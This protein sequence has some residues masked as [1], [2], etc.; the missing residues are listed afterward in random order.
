MDLKRA[1]DAFVWVDVCVCASVL[2][3]VCVCG[4]TSVYVLVSVPVCECESCSIRRNNPLLYSLLIELFCEAL[5]KIGS[6]VLGM[7]QLVASC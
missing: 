3:P 5:Q 7:V 6:N 2:V 1:S 4:C